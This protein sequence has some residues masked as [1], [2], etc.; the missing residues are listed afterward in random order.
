MSQWLDAEVLAL[1]VRVLGQLGRRGLRRD[2]PADHDELTL[3]MSYTKV[4]LD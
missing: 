1:K 2:P 4:L 3:S